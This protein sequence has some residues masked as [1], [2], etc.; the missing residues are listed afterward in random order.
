MVLTA[1]SRAL[2]W[3]LR[4]VGA[5]DMQRKGFPRI[6]QVSESRELRDVYATREEVPKIANGQGG[7]VSADT[8]RGYS[9]TGGPM[10]SASAAGKVAI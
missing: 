1:V 8:T 9:R 10:Q 2:S 4:H 5:R 6:G 7:A 3:A